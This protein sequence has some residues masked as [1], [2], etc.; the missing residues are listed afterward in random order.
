MC[1]KN[2]IELKYGECGTETTQTTETEE[3]MQCECPFRQ[4]SIDSRTLK[5]NHVDGVTNHPLINIKCVLK[6]DLSRILVNC[7]KEFSVVDKE[8]WKLS[9]IYVE[10]RTKKYEQ[11]EIV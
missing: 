9:L 2:A 6:N 4:L 8:R 11:V 1:I 10:T 7:V 5:L 3:I